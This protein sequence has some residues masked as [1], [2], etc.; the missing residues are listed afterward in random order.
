MEMRPFGVLIPAEEARRRLL[1]SVVP[2]SRTERIPVE[3]ALGRISAETVRVTRPVPAF[4][5]ASWD[6]YAVRRADTLGSSPGAP[7]T[8][9]VVGEVYAEGRYRRPLRPGESVAIATGGAVPS[10]ADAIAIFEEVERRGQEIRVPGPVRRGERIAPPGSD[11][12]RGLRI[13]DRGKGLSPS[14][15]GALAAVGRTTVRVYARP[16]VAVVPNGNEL[17]SPGR[18]ARPGAIYESNNAMLAAVIEAA[19]GI[20]CLYR[21]VPDRADRIEAA[22]RSALR[23][24]DL[25]L[26]TGGSSVG[27]RDFLPQVLPRL[28]R[29]LFHGVAVRPGKP[30]LAAVAGRRLIVGLPG[31]PASCLSNMYWLLLPVLRRLGRRPGPGWTEE[32]WSLGARL[33]G[34]APGLSTVVPLELRDG[35]AYPT[36]RG[37]HSITSLRGAGAFLLRPPGAPALPRGR[38]VPVARLDPPLGPSGPVSGANR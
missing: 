15:L 30:T 18:R 5:R 3:R 21:P 32:R 26:A 16:R 31:H 17:I 2:V 22:V 37:S 19:G 23:R 11:M 20:P 25:V 10:G 4:A 12:P 38:V 35:R 27:E 34:G 1:V 29:L 24:A 28:G 13:V 33:T 9:R 7:V 14:E 8:L 36:F 6:G